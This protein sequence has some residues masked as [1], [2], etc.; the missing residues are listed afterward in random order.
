MFV[1]PSP[2]LGLLPHGTSGGIGLSHDPSQRDA[3]H[4]NRPH[5]GYRS[6]GRDSPRGRCV[7]SC[8]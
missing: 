5:Q 1:N 4:V 6:G 8:M 2:L 7:F 3:Y